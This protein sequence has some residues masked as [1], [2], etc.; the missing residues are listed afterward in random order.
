MMQLTLPDC[1]V[2]GTLSDEVEALVARWTRALGEGSHLAIA[3]HAT[4]ARF[5]E[6]G[7]RALTRRERERV[8]AYFGA[9]VRRALMRGSEAGARQARRRLVEA[10]IVADLRAA[11]WG[12]ERAVDEARAVTAGSARGTAA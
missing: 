1:E 11:G 7:H 2:T 3:S 5:A 8:G 6:W 12:V 10:S 4:N 9:V